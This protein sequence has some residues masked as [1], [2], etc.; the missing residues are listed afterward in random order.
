MKADV[1]VPPLAELYTNKF[2]QQQQGEPQDVAGLAPR[3]P[4]RANLT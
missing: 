3:R 4:S 1:K 2:V